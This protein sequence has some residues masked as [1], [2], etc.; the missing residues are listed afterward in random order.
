MG[1]EPAACLWEVVRGP[2]S[3]ALSATS[4]THLELF[5]SFFTCWAHTRVDVFGSKSDLVFAC[6]LCVHVSPEEGRG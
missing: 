6:L 5:C 2:G 1:R 3:G 4:S